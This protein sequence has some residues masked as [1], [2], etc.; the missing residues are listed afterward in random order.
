[1]LLGEYQLNLGEKNRVA[2][3][4]KLRMELNGTLIISRGYE[5]CL[6]LLDFDRWESFIKEINKKPLFSLDVRD[7]KR[8]VLGGAHEIELDSQGRFVLPDSLKTF[9]SIEQSVI[10]LGIGEWVELW[11]EENWRLKLES[12]SKNVSDIAERLGGKI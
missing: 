11:S 3:P 9:A 2:I 1:M 6:I 8:F 7:T 4:K 12:L 10:F 5:K